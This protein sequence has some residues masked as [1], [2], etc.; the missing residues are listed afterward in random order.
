MFAAEDAVIARLSEADLSDLGHRFPEIYRCIARELSRRL[1]QR[2]AL[3]NATREKIRVFIISSAEALIVARTIQNAFARD[4]FTTVVWTDGVFKISNYTL[5]S[6]EDEVDNSDFAIAIAHADDM[7]ESRGKEWPA[8]RDNVIF[9]L[10][11]FMG[12]LGRHRAILM[13]PRDEGVKLPSDLAGITTIPYR[14]QKDSDTA[15]VMA[16]ACN[17]LR[18]HILQF[19]PNN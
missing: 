11:L 12:R 14:F 1:M 19:G 16:P 6:L 4:P 17:S 8:P 13:E 10:G 18:D 5:Q 9:E 7:T 3:V 15:A 2:N